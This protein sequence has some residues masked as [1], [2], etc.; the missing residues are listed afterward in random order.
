MKVEIKNWLGVVVLLCL[1]FILGKITVSRDV[2]ANPQESTVGR[3]QLT[4]GTIQSWGSK[5]A[6][7]TSSIFRIDTQTGMVE[8]WSIYI[9]E[10]GYFSKSWNVLKE[11]DSLPEKLKE[12]LEK[13]K[14][15]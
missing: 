5:D 3:Y 15:K 13:L 9:S 10:E 6:H 12:K 4:A 2:K 1:G 11:E 8:Q 7:T 14:K